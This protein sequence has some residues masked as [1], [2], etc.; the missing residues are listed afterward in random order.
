MNAL[1]SGGFVEVGYEARIV[2]PEGDVID[3]IETFLGRGVF[4]VADA[5]DIDYAFRLRARWPECQAR[6][7]CLYS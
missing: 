3:D 4:V 7:Q 2:R 6:Y 1:R 5:F